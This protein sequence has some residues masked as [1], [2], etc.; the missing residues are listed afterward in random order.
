Q[1][2]NVADGAT[3]WAEKFD[4]KFT[5]I[6]SLE[7][8]ISEQVAE[9]LTLKLTQKL[10]N[11]L[12]KRYTENTTAYQAYLKGRFFL[13]RRTEESYRNAIIHFKEAIRI[14]PEYALAYTGVADYYQLLA[15]LNVMTPQECAANAKDAILRAI[16]IDDSIAEAH[17]SLAYVR[18]CSE[19]DW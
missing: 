3:I 1:L 4:E 15:H 17:L 14:D 12:K 13:S 9:A 18:T 10:R 16:E 6:F 19:W 2:V 11:Q 5:N 7:D 8:S